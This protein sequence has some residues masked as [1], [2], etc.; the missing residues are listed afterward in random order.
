MSSG[1]VF[2]LLSLAVR[3]AAKP[4]GNYIKRQAKEH[5]GFRKFAIKQA[6]RVHW[7][8]M[9]MRLGILHDPEAQQRMHEREQKAAEERK[10]KAETPTVRTE[11]EQKEYEEQQAR[12]EKE[13]KDGK[14]KEDKTPRITIRPLSDARAIELGANFFSEMFVFGVAAGLILVESWR[15]GKKESKRRDD[16]AERLAALESE[17]ERLRSRYEPE[18]AEIREKVKPDTTSSWWN[19]A[20]WWT[21]TDPKQSDDVSDSTAGTVAIAG[22]V[23]VQQPDK[24]VKPPESAAQRSKAAGSWKHDNA[25][26]ASER[27]RSA[28][29]TPE[30][31]V[32]RVDSVSAAKKER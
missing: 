1:V 20:G 19:P 27:A 8:D 25:S 18:L 21:R 6:Q 17:V 9:R 30:A 4:I 26:G 14:K 13:R 11:A 22:N 23:P 12:S 31:A 32:E 29:S 24:A 10:R 2:K 7:L 15:S 5:E 3:T 16:V 28:T